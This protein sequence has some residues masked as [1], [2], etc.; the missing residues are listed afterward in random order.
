[1]RVQT[2]RYDATNTVTARPQGVACASRVVA[3]TA[4]GSIIAAVITVHTATNDPNEPSAV[5]TPMFMSCISRIAT[6][7]AAAAPRSVVIA[8]AVA[9]LRALVIA[10]GS[11]LRSVDRRIDAGVSSRRGFGEPA[12]EV[13][14]AVPMRFGFVD[15]RQAVVGEAHERAVSV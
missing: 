11:A 2:A 14:P 7:P 3:G 1:M 6:A 9:A 12:E 10:R 15:G 4:P 5:A 13:I 8:A